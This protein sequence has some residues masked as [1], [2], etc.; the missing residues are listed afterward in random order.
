MIPRDGIHH[1]LVCICFVFTQHLSLNMLLSPV[2]QTAVVGEDARAREQLKN[3]L[4]NRGE[5]LQTILEE[6]HK[7][8]KLPELYKKSGWDNL[9]AQQVSKIRRAWGEL[10]ESHRNRILLLARQRGQLED[11][12][13]TTLSTARKANI[14]VHEKVRI[15]HLRVFPGAIPIWA[16]AFTCKPRPLLDAAGSS[17]SA[18]REI[19]VNPWAR[20]AEIFN[21]FDAFQPQNMVCSYRDGQK[22]L[23]NRNQE[24][25]S[26]VVFDALKS[27]NPS[28][29]V[30]VPRDADFIK[31]AWSLLKKDITVT[32][33]LY[34]RSG[35]HDG[36]YQSSRGIHS[37]V[38][39]FAKD[40]STKYAI[41]IF[42]Q[43]LLQS[44]G[45]VMEAGS[46]MDTGVLAGTSAA[47]DALQLST[48]QLGRAIKDSSAE[49]KARRKRERERK[50]QL[51][52]DDSQ[53]ANKPKRA[54]EDAVTNDFNPERI[55][56][57]EILVKNPNGAFYKR[58][59]MALAEMA[60]GKGAFPE[61]DD[62]QDES[63]DEIAM[64]D[65][66]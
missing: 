47:A 8:K 26:T 36:D 41:V 17:E 27:L 10:D 54:K 55:M 64:P 46:G 29:S 59:E 11:N 52:T 30:G 37:W 19:A 24:K 23:E 44:L 14:T 32:E 62:D 57:L 53:S 63:E 50:L 39:G 31:D 21:D 9:K 2:E 4:F 28:Q 13:V 58:A 43:G 34:Y 56:A 49:R 40:L 22:L 16:E 65:L 38:T 18:E 15:M 5:H 33:S 60:F 51:E 6:G 12:V 42:D 61:E 45:K 25:I 20:L 3:D 48:T 1:I 66:S 7:L 35:N